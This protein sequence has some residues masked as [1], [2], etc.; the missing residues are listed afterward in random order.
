MLW[1]TAVWTISSAAIRS[2]ACCSPSYPRAARNVRTWGGDLVG[3]DVTVD[4]PVGGEAP[5]EAVP[6]REAAAGEL[7]EGSD[8]GEGG[9]GGVADAA[10]GVAQ[11]DSHDRLLRLGP[12][13]VV[14]SLDACRVELGGD[15]PRVERDGLA[16]PGHVDRPA[17]LVLFVDLPLLCRGRLGAVAPVEVRLEL[18]ALRPHKTLPSAAARLVWLVSRAALYDTP[19][20]AADRID[21][22]GAADKVTAAAAAEVTLLVGDDVGEKDRSQGHAGRS[23]GQRRAGR[24]GLGRQPAAVFCGG[25]DRRARRLAQTGEVGVE[26]PRSDVTAAMTGKF[27]TPFPHTLHG[28]VPGLCRSLAICTQQ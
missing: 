25:D 2:A 18:V 20:L 24:G 22:D 4:L 7:H 12:F 8:Q 9:G 3:V 14:V 13:D 23:G 19:A 17:E 11:K 16:C 28:L 1:A 5:D 15:L 10:A 6:F 27:L 21:V 26:P